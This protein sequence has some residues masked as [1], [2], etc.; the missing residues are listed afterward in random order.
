MSNA[1]IQKLFNSPLRFRNVYVE[2]NGITSNLIEITNKEME[3]IRKSSTEA[4]GDLSGIPINFTRYGHTI[5]VWPSPEIEIGL[6]FTDIT[7]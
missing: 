2:I 4:T 5:A 1:K 3:E 6:I 7:S